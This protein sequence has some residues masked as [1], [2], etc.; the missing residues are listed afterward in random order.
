M[1]SGVNTPIRTMVFDQRPDIRLIVA[2][3][4]G[5]LL[6]RNNRVHEHFWPLVTELHRQGI[7]FCPA[8]GRQY[9]TLREQFADIADDLVFIAENG[10]YV[11]RHGLEVSSDGL[12]AADAVR[13]IDAMRVSIA[14]G[15]DAGVVLCG[16]RSAYI[17][18]SD[19][20]FLESVVP[21]YAELT[22]VDDL[23]DVDDE[24]L[25]VSIYDFGAAEDT[26]APL[27]T[28]FRDSHTV[29]VSGEHWVDVTSSTANKGRAIRHLQQSVGIGPDQTMVFGDFLNDLEMMD[30]ATFSFAMDNAHPELRERAGY[31]AP[32]NLENGVVRTISSVLGLP[33]S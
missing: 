30:A 25:K 18:R 9:F 22:V 2:D 23:L 14:C 26:T 16:K 11:V 28:G 7:L 20:A 8:S 12:L 24:F 4:D 15:L 3:M 29:R 19:A 6:D 1:H 33:W 21:Y 31:L 13:L 10:S 27:L 32:S 5:T 17:E